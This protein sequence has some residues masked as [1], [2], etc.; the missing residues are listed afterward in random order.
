M[1]IDQSRRSL[2]RVVSGDEKFLIN[3]SGLE[4]PYYTQG[5]TSN[6]AAARSGDREAIQMISE[7][8]S[9]GT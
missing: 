3:H 7:L 6:N 5:N 2:M 4:D 8:Q 9:R 1:S